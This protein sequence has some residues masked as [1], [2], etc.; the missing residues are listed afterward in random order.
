MRT[1]I[2]L[3]F[4]F[5]FATGCEGIGLA[6]GLYCGLDTCYDVLEIERDQFNKSDL[7]RIYRKL[8]R[9]Y[10]PGTLDLKIHKRQE[11]SGR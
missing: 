4:L 7:P 5:S 2:L 3:I 6:P 9:K 11:L 8:A 10:H 1:G